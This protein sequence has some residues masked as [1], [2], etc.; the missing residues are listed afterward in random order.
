MNDLLDKDCQDYL[1]E[2][3]L[4]SGSREF[5][6]LG[7]KTSLQFQLQLPRNLCPDFKTNRLE[8]QM[9]WDMKSG[10]EVKTTDDQL[11]DSGNER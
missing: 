7:L 9:K 2:Y 5:L 1:I 8:T 11:E 4:G 6:D 3:C 10:C